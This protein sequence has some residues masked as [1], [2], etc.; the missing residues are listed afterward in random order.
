VVGEE[1]VGRLNA[2]AFVGA[3]EP[4]ASGS[5]RAIDGNIGLYDGTDLKAV[6][7]GKRVSNIQNGADADEILILDH[8]TGESAGRIVV[9]SH[10]ISVQR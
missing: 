3:C 10:R 4:L 5:F 9:T 8:V 1:T 6:I 2:V 7:Y